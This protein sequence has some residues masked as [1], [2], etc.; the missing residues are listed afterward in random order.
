MFE[1]DGPVFD[2]IART[3]EGPQLYAEP[4]FTYLNR[5]ARPEIVEVRS[6]IEEWFGNYPI[7]EQKHLQDRLRS[8]VDHQH[9]S[10]LFELLL[11]E[12]LI[13]L[14]CRVEVHP[15]VTKNT[16]KRPDFMAT[17]PSGEQF[18]L[19]ATLA[20]AKS[21]AEAAAQARIN[22]VYDAI[23]R[24]DSPDYFIGLSVKG[25]PQSPPSAKR[26]K[27]FLRARLKELDFD[28]VAGMHQSYPEDLP[29][30]T[31][32]HDGWQID[33]RPIPKSPNSRGKPGIRPIGLIS[34][35][36]VYVD[37][38]TPLRQAIEEKAG[39]Y[40]E[41]GLPYLVAV[42]ALDDYGVDNID[43]MEALFGQEM[44]ITSFNSEKP[45]DWTMTRN[46]DGV[47]TSHSGP[48]YTRLSGVLF[49]SRFHPGMFKES[50]VK[51]IH[52]PWAKYPHR[53]VLCN[54]PQ[55]IVADGKM[56][57]RDGL[58]LVDILGQGGTGF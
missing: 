16:D 36:Y 33:F 57:W 52:N 45:D 15:S 2:S 29:V 43:L 34:H 13:R 56:K 19:E 21:K 30:W 8:T 41:L 14:G 27:A 54:L 22:E 50:E 55:G 37:S 18:I 10:A 47:W 12:M 3:D 40:G 32:E 7:G 53:S 17:G 35:E 39:R 58:S 26:M 23:N 42:N 48:R 51:L 5:S 46:P 24:L 38:R 11:H 1:D 4:A 31:F 49:F 6:T 20:T 44:W 28:E 9:L 25:A